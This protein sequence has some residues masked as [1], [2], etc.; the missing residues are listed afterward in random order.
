ME[1]TGSGTYPL[2]VS[3]ISDVEPSGYIREFVY[4]ASSRDVIG[5]QIGRSSLGL[6][7]SQNSM[8]KV[9][10]YGS[11]QAILLSFV[12]VNLVQSHDMPGWSLNSL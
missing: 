11:H 3:D 8:W 9:R 12:S 2:S 7:I 5:Y 1:E 6:T 4:P 10:C